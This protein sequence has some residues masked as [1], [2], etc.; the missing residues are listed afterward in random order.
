MVDR[1]IKE[2]L[3]RLYNEDNLLL[4]KNN[5]L[6]PNSQILEI[7]HWGLGGQNTTLSL[8]EKFNEKGKIHGITWDKNASVIKESYPNINQHIVD[9]FNFIPPK[10]IKYDLIVMDMGATTTIHIW[11]KDIRKKL[12]NLLN[13]K[14]IIIAYIFNNSKYT[15]ESEI[16]DKIKNHLKN[17]WEYKDCL[18]P[19]EDKYIENQLFKKLGDIYNIL[20]I[21]KED[22]KKRGRKY[23]SWITLQK[24]K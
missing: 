5:I 19:M 13:D 23:I 8:I 9:Y 4:R 17:Y 12:Y 15:K 16:T 20:Y 10:G 3:D 2:I 11:E 6:P 24:N 14:G 7:G 22:T 18:I 1:G 21:D